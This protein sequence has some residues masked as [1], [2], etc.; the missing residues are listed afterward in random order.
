MIEFQLLVFDYG[1]KRT[2][3]AVGQS[4]TGQASPL[5]PLAMQNG[6][7]DWAQVE[8]LLSRWKPDAVLVGLPLNMDGSVS[9]M[10]RRANKFRQRL[11]GRFV[12]PALGWDERLTSEEMKREARAQ[13]VHDFGRHSVDSLAAGLIFESWYE[14]L[15]S[16]EEWQAHTLVLG[17]LSQS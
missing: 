10:A 17:D 1:I 13:G 7:P 9:D 12:L 11:H 6:Q 14:S 15:P 3:V 4:I 16:L 2:G 8:L 5:E